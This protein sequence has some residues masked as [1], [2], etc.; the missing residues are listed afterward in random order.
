VHDTMVTLLNAPLRSAD[1]LDAS[2]WYGAVARSE[3]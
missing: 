3:R 2:S 1:V